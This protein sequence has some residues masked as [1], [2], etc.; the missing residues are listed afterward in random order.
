MLFIT[1][2]DPFSINIEI[3]FPLLQREHSYP[4]IVIGSWW[5]WQNQTAQRNRLVFQHLPTTQTLQILQ[6]ENLAK[7]LYFYNIDAQNT[8]T[9]AEQLTPAERGRLAITALQALPTE[10]HVG[11]AI[12][13]CPLDKHACVAGG[14]RFQGQTEF[15]AAHYQCETLMLLASPQLK[16]ALATNHVAIKDLPLRLTQETIEK[17]IRLF[18]TTLQKYFA[19]H[20][21]KIAVCGLNPHCGEGGIFGNEEAEIINPALHACQKHSD[22]TVVGAL[23]ADSVFHLALQGNY[24]GVLA[25]YHDQGLTPLKTH[26]FHH[27]VNITAGL[28]VLRISPDHGTATDLFRQRQASA[29]SFE[30]CFAHINAYLRN[31]K[32]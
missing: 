25:M 31:K 13:T 20:H 30:C 23:P 9:P 28:P 2:G 24:D 29:T 16:V 10:T 6:Q 21:P 27:T 3:L 19:C 7:G 4:C 12:L 17:K 22:F 14:Y 15:F 32:Q 11:T 5:H 26:D 8:S 18:A 1:L